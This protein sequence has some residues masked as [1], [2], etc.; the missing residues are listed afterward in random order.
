[1]PITLTAL[2]GVSQVIF[3]IQST[4][5]F[6]HLPFYLPHQPFGNW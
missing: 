4:G 6:S 3:T 2:F 1:M 5:E